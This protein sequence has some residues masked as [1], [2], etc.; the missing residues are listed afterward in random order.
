VYDSV[1]GVGSVLRHSIMTTCIDYGLPYG[2]GQTIIF[3]SCR[4]FFFLLFSPR[5]IS[6]IAERMSAILAHMVWP[7]CEFKMQV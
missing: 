7:W 5:L 1:S 4:L 2:I 3:S 6:A